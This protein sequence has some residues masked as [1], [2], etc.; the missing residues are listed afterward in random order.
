[1][2]Y[3]RTGQFFGQTN[4]IIQLEGITLTDT[5][6]THDKVDWHYHENAYFTF[7]LE[8]RV[9]EGNK[10]EIYNCTP[11][12]LLFH[13]WQESHY[14]IKPRGF[15][16]GFHI[17]LEHNWFYALDI[18]MSKLQGSINL[19]HPDLRILMYNIFR[20]TRIN[21]NTSTLSIQAL[22]TALL[23]RMAATEDSTSGKIPLW[24]S[25]LRDMLHDTATDNWSLKALSATLGIHPVHLSRDFKKYFGCTLGE[26]IRKVKV[27]QSL[28]LFLNKEL[29]LTH[30]ALA[31][32]FADQSHFIRCFK[33]VNGY[34]PSHYRNSLLD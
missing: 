24:V 1:M 7:I 15:T 11:G 33:A 12:S 3:L 9:L 28:S 34:K 10:K 20:E 14:N 27:Q 22:L 8:G 30:I 26:Y 21:D 31:S 16:R 25:A 18:D 32:G 13:N 19:K 17:E 2:E 23:D 5:E 29:S 4:Q 6:Y